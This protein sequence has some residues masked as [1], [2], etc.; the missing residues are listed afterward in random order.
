ML[1][2][3]GEGL[4]HCETWVSDI[5]DDSGDEDRDV[6][7]SLLASSRLLSAR[8]KDGG[9]MA[10]RI[11]RSRNREGLNAAGD[12]DENEFMTHG[13]IEEYDEVVEG[14]RTALLGKSGKKNSPPLQQ[15]L[16]KKKKTKKSNR[17]NETIS[18]CSSN[19]FCPDIKKQ[20]KATPCEEALAVADYVQQRP[21]GLQKSKVHHIRKKQMKKDKRTRQR[22]QNEPTAL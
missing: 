22:Q 3:D 14:S 12:A 4:S 8:S 6:S 11:K 15:S 7:S 18:T 1:F 19:S 21:P 16:S 10:K 2:F 20:R 9:E 17:N 5:K 13:T